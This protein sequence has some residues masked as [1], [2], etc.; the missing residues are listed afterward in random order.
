MPDKSHVGRRYS[1]E[2]QVVDPG[3]AATFASAVAGSDPVASDLGAVPPTFAAVYCL[4]PTLGQII[5]DPE[6]GI[7]LDGMVHGEQQFTWHEPVAV[8]DVLDS[9]ATIA[10]VEDK[11]GRTFVTVALEATRPQGGARVLSGRA[12]LLLAGAP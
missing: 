11:R 2:G 8:G 12:L 1:A 7:R 4:F 6:L 9:T 3:G 5:L 10:A